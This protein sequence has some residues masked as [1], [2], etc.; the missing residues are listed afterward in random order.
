[1][2]L[3]LTQIAELSPEKQELLLQHLLKQSKSESQGS[4]QRQPRNFPAEAPQ[5]FPLS[6]AQERL[7]FLHQFE[8]E[9]TAYNIPMAISIHGKLNFAALEQSLNAIIQR[10]EILRTVFSSQDDQPIQIILPERSLSLEVIDLRHLSESQQNAE[11]QHLAL[12]EAQHPFD[13]KKEPLLRS[14]ILHLNETEQVALFAMHHSISDAWSMQVLI[15]EVIAFYTAFVTGTPAILPE[16]PIQYADF[17]VWQRQW[18]QDNHLEAQLTYWKQQLSGTP[19]LLDLPTSRSRPALQTYRGA[20]QSILLPPSFSQGLKKLARQEGATLFMVLLAAFKVLLYRY[21]QQEDLWVGTP[22]AN[23][24]RSQLEGLIGFFV[25]TQVLRTQVTAEESFRGFL[26]QVKRIAL[27][28]YAHQDLPFEQLVEALQPERDPSRNPLFDVMFILQNAPTQ[29][30]EFPGLSLTPLKVENQTSNFDLTLSMVESEQG[31][32]AQLEY[33]T[34]LFNA[35]TILGMLTH[36]QILL[37][38]IIAQPDQSLARLPLLTPAETQQLLRDWNNTY[39]D[40]PQCQCIHELLEAQVEENPEAIAVVFNHQSLTYRELNNRANQVAHALIDAGVGPEVRVGLCMERSLELIISVLG[41]LKAGGAYVPLD[42]N[43]PRERLNFILT[44]A[45]ISILFTQKDLISSLPTDKAQVILIEDIEPAERQDNPQYHVAPD[46]LAYVIYTSGS[47]GQPK[48][49][50]IEHQSLINAYFAWEDAYQ[51]KSQATIHL[52]MANFAFD[53]FTGDWVRALCSGGKLVL[54]PRET[55][56]DPKALYALMQ[57]HHVNCAEFVPAVLRTLM[58]YLEETQQDLGFMNLLICGSDRWLVQEHQTFRRLCGSQTRLINSFGL[59]EAT[60]DSS[61][62]ENSNVTLLPEQLVPIGKPFANT[63]LY[64]LDAHLN[65]VPVGVKGE[66]YIGGKGLARGYWNRPELTAERFIPNPF[67]PVSIARLYRTGDLA[68]FL[69]DGN[70]EFLDRLDYQVKIRGVRIELG[71]IEAAIARYPLIQQAIVTAYE[72]SPTNVRL[73]AYVVLNESDADCDP[74]TLSQTLRDYL[75]QSLTECM[76]PSAFVLLDTMPLT[77]N[78]K[79]DR[80]ALPI[81]NKAEFGLDRPFSAPQTVAEE[82]IANIWKQILNIER[83]G[84]HDN[85]FNLGGHSLLATRVIS[86]LQNDFQADELPLR[87]LFESPTVAGLVNELTRIW[88]DRQTVEQ[89]A[90]VLKSMESL[91]AAD[92]DQMLLAPQIT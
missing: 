48:G 83:V 31:L 64:I 5:S 6:F 32:K 41:I 16:L 61:Y 40:Y 52:Q 68:R 19:S 56:L 18:F 87:C 28:A 71:E 23:R 4:I 54:C 46:D 88:G 63:Q 92:I 62:F 85:F 79:V 86:R 59:T 76:I 44:D 47:T 84:I 20:T 69:P 42:P 75:S 81:P 78:G 33:S 73:V 58:E 65:P 70:I 27:E 10:H 30:L 29:A 74:Q 43:I 12:N 55:L 2:S 9:S 8:P 90:E 60:I 14:T 39:R 1:M 36:F 7:W 53:V 89:I 45:D 37:A 11:V 3:S 82:V 22:I 57:Q 26:S 15:Q 72:A 21:T 24:N 91:S 35:H 49:V 80:R 17:G 13:L 67:N 34:D 51:L 38:G 50:M 66:L 25:N 77:P